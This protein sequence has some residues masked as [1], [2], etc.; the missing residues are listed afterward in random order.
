MKAMLEIVWIIVALVGAT[1]PCTLASLSLR[2]TDWPIDLEPPFRPDVFAY[3]ATLDFAMSYFYID[4][5]AASGC[6]LSSVPAGKI[7]VRIGGSV[8]NKLY[9]IHPDTEEQQV[10]V[11]T[12]TRLL[13]SET[14]IQALRVDG[15]ELSPVFDPT[16]R[17]YTVNLALSNDEAIVHYKLRDN[18]QRTRSSAKTEHPTALQHSRRANTSIAANTNDTADGVTTLSRRLLNPEETRQRTSGEVQYRDASDVFMVD[19]GFTRTLE[20]TVQCADATQANIGIYRLEVIR[21]G[22]VHERPFFDPSKKACVNFCPSGFYRNQETHRCSQCNTHCK[23]CSGLLQ[24]QMCDPDNAEYSYM[25]QPDGQCLQVAN[26]LFKKYRWWCV[27]LGTLLALLVLIGCVGFCQLCCLQGRDV[28]TW[29]KPTGGPTALYTFES[30][31]EETFA[32][33]VVKR[34]LGLY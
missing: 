9:S 21:P 12:A 34:K 33:P 24:C 14:E 28:T 15:G 32:H 31:A 20:L 26:H 19:V 4:A 11:I 23:V 3:A 5:R 29:S 22:C 6:Q 30:D 25:V 27:G 16:I 18:E 1:K 17:S 13:G 7:P 8:E 2:Y 10:Y